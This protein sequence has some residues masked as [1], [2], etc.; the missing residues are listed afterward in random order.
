[1]ADRVLRAYGGPIDLCIHHH[2]SAHEVEKDTDGFP[3]FCSG[4]REVTMTVETR[5][6]T[7]EEAADLDPPA[8]HMRRRLIT[9]WEIVEMRD[10]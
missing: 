8:A 3:I 10:V 5:P 1:M 2:P 4:G 6:N 7:Y 9:D